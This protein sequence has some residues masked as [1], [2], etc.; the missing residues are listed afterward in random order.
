[1][2]F[3][4]QSIGL[5]AGN[6]NPSPAVGRSRCYSAWHPFGES[7]TAEQAFPSGKGLLTTLS[8]LAAFAGKTV[9]GVGVP[10]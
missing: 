3:G 9:R 8:E 7:Q 10:S 2:V 4:T 5:W 1:M 6:H